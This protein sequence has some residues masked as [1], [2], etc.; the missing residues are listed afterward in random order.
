MWIIINANCVSLRKHSPTHLR[1]FS[2][3]IT[4]LCMHVCGNASA[5]ARSLVRQ[6]GNKFWIII[7]KLTF[8]HNWITKVF[9]MQSHF[10]I[11]FCYHQQTRHFILQCGRIILSK[12][13]RLLE[14]K[15]F[16][17]TM[18]KVH[19]FSVDVNKLNVLIFW[20]YNYSVVITIGCL[21][22]ICE[23]KNNTLESGASNSCHKMIRMI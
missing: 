3:S 7:C 23:V 6:C 19:T 5:L 10:E 22:P 12:S 8:S 14:A 13:N 18:F 15:A 2:S 16:G 20:C 21:K 4:V 11:R 1:D 17:S 9:V